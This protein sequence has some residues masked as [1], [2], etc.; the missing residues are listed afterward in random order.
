MNFS[1]SD[2]IK[3]YYLARCNLLSSNPIIVARHFQYCV[4]VFFKEIVIDW[5][6]HCTMYSCR[7]SN[8]W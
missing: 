2:I 3:F 4:E 8:S 6:K 1:E 7:I 5:E